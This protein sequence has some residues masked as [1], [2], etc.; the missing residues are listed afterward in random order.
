MWIIVRDW[1]TGCE[2]TASWALRAPSAICLYSSALF[3]QTKLWLRGKSLCYHLDR[4]S[5]TEIGNLH[6]FEQNYFII[7]Q[8]NSRRATLWHKIGSSLAISVNGSLKKHWH[9]ST[10]KR[11]CPAYLTKGFGSDAVE[12]RDC[13]MFGARHAVAA[14][15]DKVGW[16]GILLEER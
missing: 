10:N 16:C 15:C 1:S 4:I 9:D 13:E 3:S 6:H 14:E 2:S 7:F 8:S 5:Q 12:T 11:L